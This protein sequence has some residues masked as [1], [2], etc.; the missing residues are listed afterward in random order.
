[1]GGAAVLGII[2]AIVFL[3]IR[4]RNRQKQSAIEKHQAGLAPAHD[5]APTFPYAFDPKYT[6][7]AASQPIS[8]QMLHNG[9]AYHAPVQEPQELSST[10]VEQHELDAS[11]SPRSESK[12][13]R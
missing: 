12:P 10:P 9:S 6:P 2:A 11:F 8:P 4:R 13:V 5:T 1:V 3:L 7:Y